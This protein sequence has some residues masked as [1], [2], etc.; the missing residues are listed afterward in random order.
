MEQLVLI[1]VVVQNS[2]VT[3]CRP[4]LLRHLFL[5]DGGH[6]VNSLGALGTVPLSS[7]VGY[8]TTKFSENLL[9]QTITHSQN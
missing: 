7:D 5:N 4:F 2:Q 8:E 6:I 9:S 3:A 1:W